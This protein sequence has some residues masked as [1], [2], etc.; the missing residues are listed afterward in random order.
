MKPVTDDKY[1]QKVKIT[2][3]YKLDF[4]CLQQNMLIGL[5]RKMFKPTTSG[6]QSSNN[7]YHIT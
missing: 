6:K 7:C 5:L 1:P 4:N 3:A 2:Y